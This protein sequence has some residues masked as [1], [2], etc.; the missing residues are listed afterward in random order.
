MLE[1]IASSKRIEVDKSKIELISNLPSPKCV[2]DVRLFLG[3]MGL[4]RQFIKD[5]SSISL[6]L[7]YLLA[8]DASFQSTC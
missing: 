5:F 7:C 4:S 1:H 2:K 3:H 8:N 6:S